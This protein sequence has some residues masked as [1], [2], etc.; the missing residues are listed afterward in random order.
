MKHSTAAMAL[1]AGLFIGAAAA[2]TTTP[3][4]ADAQNSPCDSDRQVHVLALNM[5]HEA[6]GEGFDA[7][8]AVGQVTLNRVN[9][10]S[11]ADNICDVVYQ[12]RQF[13]WT[14]MR[15]NHTPQETESWELALQIAEHLILGE[16]DEMVA[17]ATHFLN[18]R[19]V[20]RVPNWAREY[21]VVGRVG[22]HV[23]Y[24]R[25]S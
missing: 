7:M 9:H 13:S 12:R 17:G 5:Y 10:P 25:P 22:N 6:R 8:A 24:A 16:M 14:H 23:F 20:R 3:A 21:E 1:L 11:Y 4:I 15:R 19:L 18:P 2:T